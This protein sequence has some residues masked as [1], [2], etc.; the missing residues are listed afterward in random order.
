MHFKELLEQLQGH[1]MA[2]PK[3]LYRSVSLPEL[4][5]ILKTGKVTGRQNT[6]NEF[7]ERRHV[8]FGDVL[9][10]E[11]IFQGEDHSRVAS[12]ALA[13]HGIHQ[14]FKDNHDAKT[15][16]KQEIESALDAHMAR[17][18]ASRTRRG[19]EPID[20]ESRNDFRW[21]VPK[22]LWKEHD[23]Y[24]DRDRAMRKKYIEMLRA[25]EK[26]Y[27]GKLAEQPYSSA[28]LQ[29]K[30]I[31][32]GVEYSTDSQMKGMH[33]YGFDSGQVTLAD[34][35][36]VYLIKDRKIVKQAT[37]DQLPRLLRPAK[38]DRTAVPAGSVPGEPDPARG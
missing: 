13:G 5:D 14:R 37:P 3:V 22:E 28:V 10:D 4:K 36:K 6:F 30:P 20:A 32:G 8:F 18:N 12:V 1:P 7:E 33:E 31:S 17:I 15:A 24:E 25:W 26:K 19:L 16:A 2:E 11:L 34:I 23:K 29:T 9:N 38:L 35:D 21:A 27:R